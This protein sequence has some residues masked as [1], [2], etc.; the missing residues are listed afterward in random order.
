MRQ[1]FCLV[2]Q[3]PVRCRLLFF[4]RATQAFQCDLTRCAPDIASA[5][6]GDFCQCKLL[7]EVVDVL[8]QS[9]YSAAFSPFV[10]GYLV[11]EFVPDRAT[12]RSAFNAAPM[13]LLLLQIGNRLGEWDAIEQAAAPYI[14][15]VQTNDICRRGR[16]NLDRGSE[17]R[18][19]G[20]QPITKS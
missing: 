14:V 2:F 7:T 11:G 6:Q 15:V 5:P 8:E 3:S 12:L 13:S 19:R 10:K 4:C 9:A 17:R 16:G 20:F 18:R 1:D